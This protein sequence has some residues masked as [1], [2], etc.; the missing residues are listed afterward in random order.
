MAKAWE[1]QKGE[2]LVSYQ[3]FQRYLEAARP[4]SIADFAALE[5]CSLGSIRRLFYKYNWNDR[6]RQYDN[7][8]YSAEVEAVKRNRAKL[9]E[10]RDNRHVKF[11]MLAQTKGANILAKA[12]ASI[13]VK[14]AI[15]LLE[16]GIK[17]EREVA[18]EPSEIHKHEIDVPNEIKIRIVT[19]E[20]IENERRASPV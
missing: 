19:R 5:K 6:A 10:E 8:I 1:R 7:E 17:I 3:K 9:A 2:T 18:G 16:L 20:D 12:D 11:A 15:R 13:S 14:D 4:M